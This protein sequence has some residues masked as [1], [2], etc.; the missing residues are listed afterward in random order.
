MVVGSSSVLSSPSF[1]KGSS[2]HSLFFVIFFIV[3]GFSITSSAA[4]ISYSDQCS[5]IVPESSPTVQ[6]FISLPFSHI[7]NGYCLGGDIIINQDPSHYS[8]NFSKV[9]VFETRKVYRTEVESVF[10][11]DGNLN[12]LSRNM[13]YSGGDSGDGGSSNS[14]GLP[15]SSWFG[16]VSFRLQGFWLKSSARLCMV[17]SGSAYSREGKLLNLAAVLKLDNVKNSSTVTDLFSGTLESLDLADE[18]D[19]FEPIS[20]SVFPQMNYEYTLISEENGTRCSGET[21]VLEGFIT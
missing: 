4:Q 7:P 11:V 9:I 20:I 17:G 18:S 12:L 14:Q 2:L 1:L 3:H 16:S 8:A 13:Y 6:E 10:K 5:S 15:P 19:Y 21:N